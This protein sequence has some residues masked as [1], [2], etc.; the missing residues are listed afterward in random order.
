MADPEKL[1]IPVLHTSP[2]LLVV[3]P[4][5]KDKTASER[6]IKDLRL[7]GAF[8]QLNEHIQSILAIRKSPDETFRIIAK[9]KYIFVADAL[10][11]FYQQWLHQSKWPYMGVQ[12][13]FKGKKV[14][15][16]ACQGTKGM[17]EKSDELMA[18][19]LLDMIVDEQATQDHRERPDPQN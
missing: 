13:P 15:T 18:K 1:G 2:L 11:Y 17:S 19:C 14:I 7:V 10:D 8:N 5:A 12:K 16:R 4:K 6:N 9:F 3:K